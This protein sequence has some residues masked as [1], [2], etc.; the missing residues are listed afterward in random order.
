MATMATATATT[1][2]SNG[3]AARVLNGNSV[4]TPAVSELTR[5]QLLEIGKK[6]VSFVCI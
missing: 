1:A 3:A 4:P 2:S 6:K 5:A